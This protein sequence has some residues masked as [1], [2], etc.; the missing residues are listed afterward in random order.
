[1]VYKDS[2]TVSAENMV[3]QSYKASGSVSN[4]ATASRKVL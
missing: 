2:L 4:N 1:M 3:Q